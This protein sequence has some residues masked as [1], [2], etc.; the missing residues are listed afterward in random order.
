[1]LTRLV[2]GVEFSPLERVESRIVGGGSGGGGGESSNISVALVSVVVF[3][4]F[5]VLSPGGGGVTLQ[6]LSFVVLLPAFVLAK[7]AE[8]GNLGFGFGSIEDLFGFVTA[9]G[10]DCPLVCF[11][12]EPE[13]GG[14][15]ASPAFLN[16]VGGVGAALV[17]ERP[18]S[19]T[20][21]VGAGLSEA[22]VA[23][24]PA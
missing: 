12:S 14:A 16:S 22:F 24:E 10:L 20:E 15:G 23:S 21:F 3:V 2:Y 7:G 8:V 13:S 9:L 11:D 6:E 1:M 17:R 18:L 5:C 19:F 4:E